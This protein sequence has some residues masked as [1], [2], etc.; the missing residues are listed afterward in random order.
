MAHSRAPN[1]GLLQMAGV[2]GEQALGHL[3]GHLR[4]TAAV[5][6]S[7][8]GVNLVSRAGSHLGC[9]MG[10]EEAKWLLLCCPRLCQSPEE[11]R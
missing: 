3:P 7:S 10:G 5:T 6:H 2:G 4:A 8:V 9:Q 1:A 11:V